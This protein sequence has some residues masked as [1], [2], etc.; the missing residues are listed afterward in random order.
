[1][2]RNTVSSEDLNRST[3]LL[4][5]SSVSMGRIAEMRQNILSLR[6]FPQLKDSVHVNQ[7]TGQTHDLS[8]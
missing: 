3:E 1:M 6:C 8:K 2:V 4:L 5:G 7:T